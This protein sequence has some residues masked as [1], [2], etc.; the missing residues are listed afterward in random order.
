MI[1]TQHA[2]ERFQERV[3]SVPYSEAYRLILETGSRMR[4]RSTPRRWMPVRPAPGL[5]FAYSPDLPGVCFLI[6]EGFAVTVYERATC[7]SWANADSQHWAPRHH[8]R[9]P[10]KRPAPGSRFEDA[11]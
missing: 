5:T 10:Y 8:R 2:V 3:A 9:P 1:P 4:V 6:R 11:A 7:R